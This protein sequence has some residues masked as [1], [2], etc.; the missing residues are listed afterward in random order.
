M[1]KSKM[2]LYLF[3]LFLFV[4]PLYTQQE[5]SAAKG[6]V[7][8]GTQGMATTAHPLA[9]KAAIEMLK[10]G[11]NAVD[12]AVAAAF[13]IGVVES[14]GSGIGGGGAMVVYL[15]KEKKSIFINY[16]QQTS[17]NVNSVNYNPKTDSKSAKAIL[18][19]GTVAG[20]TEALRLYGTL[21]LSVVLQPAVEYAEQ[22]FPIDE[23]LAR[24]IL[25][26][27][28]VLQRY[29]A[30]ASIF[31]PD[32]FP[33]A[34]GD[35]LRQPDLAK[36]L[37][38]IAAEGKKGFYEGPIAE[39]LVKGVT[40]NGG[41]LTMNDL[42]NYQVHISEPVR[43]SYRGYEIVAA[44]PPQSGV[45]II[46]AMNILENANLKKMGNYVT[47]TQSAHLIA[48]TMRKI[49]A[50][51]SA[52]IQDQ[53]FGYV[54]VNGLESKAFAR[55]RYDDI[56]MAAAD[57]SDYRKTKP[58]NPSAFDD[59]RPASK[60][61]KEAD[62]KE[63]N[64][65]D[66]IND[67]PDEE[68]SSYGKSTEEL[69]D[70]WGGR[71]KQ[72][73]QEQKN[74]VESK[75]E[76]KT[77]QG[78]N[79]IDDSDAPEFQSYYHDP[80]ENDPLLV[81]N[82]FEG[83]GHTTHLSVVDK[84]GNAVSLTQTLGT[85]FGSGL[86][87]E[88]VLLNCSMANF[89]TTSAVNSIEPNK[90]PRSSIAPTIILKNGKPFMTVGSPGATRIEATIILLIINAID[91]GLDAGEANRAPRFFCQKFDDYLHLES[92]IS[93]EVKEGLK[94]K[95]HRLR[96]YGDFDLFFGGAQIIMIDQSTNTL[97]GSADP[98]RGGVAIGY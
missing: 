45:S 76:E 80:M 46:E 92:R 10:R 91:Y 83:G 6:E 4:A 88:G 40:E 75:E 38:H 9:S 32:G 84:E 51:R 18:V 74:T 90:Q 53:R 27:N 63:K 26:N 50:D 77:P 82:I 5:N 60:K 87:V 19:P 20:L 98:R 73:K 39:A 58:G 52:F 95:G 22:G 12:A 79:E 16:Y 33:L 11:G 85:F 17:E 34:E 65:T 57:P 43:G 2:F 37:K 47:S 94:K 25:D 68:R 14:D 28:E 48:E 8:V 44:G 29:P 23:T 78:D 89:S 35:T 56:N 62:V 21:P 66:E 36:T 31:M 30:T 59:K 72:L 67:D 86:V 61:F 15:Q 71:K 96:E 3:L 55:S 49:Y 64:N 13:A 42:K 54:P 24:I 41:A 7:A 1:I 69:F 70:R 97:Y 81:E 93:E